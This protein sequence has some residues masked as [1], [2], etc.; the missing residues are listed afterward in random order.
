[1]PGPSKEVLRHLAPAE[2]A[3]AIEAAQKAEET[4]LVRRLCCIRNL[5]KGDTITEAADRVGVAQPTGSRWVEAWNANGVAGL[6]PDF[7]GGRPP[8]LDAEER[9]LFKEV[10]GEHHPLTTGQVRRL[11]EEGLDVT[12][13]RRHIPRLLE[14]LGL[15]DHIRRP[16]P[17]NRPAT[18]R[19]PLEENF[20]HAL[21]ALEA[22][23]PDGGRGRRIPDD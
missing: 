19:E 9:A 22:G 8:K 18:A 5:Y 3:D 17:S 12:Y 6:E 23:L 10:L 14:T 7:G 13:S 2:L 4:R 1:M 15:D 20:E 11:L 16:G 21:A